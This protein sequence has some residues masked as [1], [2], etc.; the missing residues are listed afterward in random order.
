M[1]F[2]HAAMLAG[3]SGNQGPYQIKQSLRFDDNGSTYLN[4]TPSS[5]GNQKT[6][7]FSAWLKRGSFTA[8]QGIFCPYYGGDG[9]NESQI[10][11]KSDNTLQIYD[12]GGARLNFVTT[13]VFRDPSAWYHLVIAVDTTQA[14]EANRFKL[15]INGEQITA[16]GTSTYPTQ[17]Q[18]LGWNG[19]SRHDIGRYAQG[20]NLYYGGY[21]AEI[22]HVDGTQ[23]DPTSF[24]EYDDNDVWRPINV[25]GLT[26]GTNG[27]YINF[28]NSSNL[29]EDQAGSND[30][31]ASGFTTSG[32]GTDVM[33][34]TPTNNW[35]TLNPLSFGPSNA[36]MIEGNLRFNT[37][38]SAYGNAKGTIAVSS[39]KWYWEVTPQT[40]ATANVAGGIL[41]AAETDIANQP[42]NYAT[43]YSYYS[44]GETRHNNVDATYGAS[45]GAGDVIGTALDLDAGTLVFYKNGVSQGTAYSS[46]SGT[47]VPA[48]GDT[49]STSGTNL[50]CNFGQRAFEYTPPTGFKALNTSNLPAPEIADGSKYFSTTLYTG[51]SGSQSVDAGMA[52][53]LAWIKSRSTSQS[54]SLTDRVRGNDLVLQ[55]NEN[56]AETSG[57]IDLTSTG[58]TIGNNNAL[59][60]APGVSYVLWSW[61]AGGS[62]S[63]NTDGSEPAT[64]SANPTAGFSIVT[65]T[66]NGT[67]ETYG[68]G[69][70]V[71]PKVILAKSRNNAGNWLFMTNIIDGSM[72]YGRLNAT[73]SFTGLSFN[74][75]TSTV[76]SYNQDDT[77]T[78][79]AYCFAE[80]EGYSKFGTYTGNGSSDGPFVY[81]GFRPAYILVKNANSSTDEWEIYD[82]ARDPYNFHDKGLRA[83]TSGAEYDLSSNNRSF[84][85]L[86][87]GFK[88]RG[89]NAGINGS[90]NT[91]I[92]VAFASHP[93]GGSGVSPAT[94]R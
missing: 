84:D 74:A 5:A 15:Y 47:F 7:T 63:S 53:D 14:T 68:H 51:V 23:L 71:A 72:K 78:N 21:M 43:G 8:N 34:D 41:G 42:G 91:H 80:V 24:G 13:Q 38:T 11:W 65:M 46:V 17:N 1:S 40:T 45:Y 12:S 32:T 31:T 60:G 22:H 88:V 33:S 77:W 10:R 82:T 67:N 30:F 56:S 37:P 86:S 64:V 20:G 19:T 87:N 93:F 35:C 81:C 44:T 83:N 16:F 3:A 85:T 28:S 70:G 39:G 59:R 9:S 79:V 29:G 36:D 73:D 90:G 75:P 89:S 69:L 55:S 52:T 61:L 62:G 66:T 4:R 48:I 54:H 27:F 58:V 6:W 57:D 94:A 92:F 18:T 26:Y 76:I 50:V 49:S 25:S 2:F